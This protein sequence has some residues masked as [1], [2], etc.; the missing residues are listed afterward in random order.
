MH[1][2]VLGSERRDRTPIIRGSE[3]S[4]A[5]EPTIRYQSFKV[6]Q[7]GNSKMLEWQGRIGDSE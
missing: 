3:V 5:S 4:E 6:P 7:E 2:T 1:L